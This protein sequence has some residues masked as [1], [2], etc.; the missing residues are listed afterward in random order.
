VT[1]PIRCLAGALALALLAVACGD[2]DSSADSGDADDT[3]VDDSSAEGADDEVAQRIVSLSATATESI[4]AIGADGQLVAVD[5][6]SYYPA[7]D[8]PAIDSF[9][10]SVEAISE[11]EPDLVVL[12]F[13]PGD[14]VTGLDALGIESLMQPAAA[15]LDD[16][17]AQIE[18]LGAATGHVGEAAELVL[19]M[20]TDL[21]A[22]VAEAPDATGTTY[23]HE[24][25]EELYSLT[26]QTFAG[27]V[28]GLFGLENIADPADEDGSSFGYPQLVEEFII[29]AD[30]DLI[31]L[32]D[33]IC[34]DQDATTVAARP[35]WAEMSAVAAGNVI[36]LDD[37]IASRWGPRVVDF[38]GAIAVAL[39]DAAVPA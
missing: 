22:L 14:L 16:A 10:P 4:F 19:S 12:A 18:Q 27:E 17:Y 25:G 37:D 2:D 15:T 32:A 20:Q 3:G 8:L 7:N 34:C 30:P 35:G 33:T 11:Y 23:Y 9:S 26:S 38:A 13:D 24:L 39:E 21:D 31:F 5:N 29:D 1:R 36:E 6:F 28:H